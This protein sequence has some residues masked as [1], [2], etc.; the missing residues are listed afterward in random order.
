MKKTLHTSL[1]FCGLTLAFALLLTA[2]PAAA[3]SPDV[4]ST[5][6]GQATPYG[7]VPLA[8]FKDTTRLN[9][10]YNTSDL[11]TFL[12]RLFFAAI[13]AGA[14]LA[15]L[16]LAWAGFLYMSSD[17]WSKKEK[18]REDIRETF[19]GLFLLLGIWIILNQIN[20]DILKLRIDVLRP[21][22]GS[23]QQQSAS[24]P[25]TES[26]FGGPLEETT[27]GQDINSGITY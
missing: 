10:L 25:P 13:A 26:S 6:Y 15:V 19:L 18:A 11:G 9:D 16:R 4:D 1:V 2:T 23:T 24:T 12:N 17:L 8:E 3:A 21:A 22:P 5:Y 27:P 20:P 7:F 14:I